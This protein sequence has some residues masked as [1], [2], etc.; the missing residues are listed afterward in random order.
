MIRQKK[1]Q[2]Q[3][4]IHEFIC[5]T[6]ER[7]LVAHL[8]T[9][10]NKEHDF[11]F[12]SFLKNLEK[13]NWLSIREKYP[14]MENI[15]P[16]QKNNIEQ[17][18]QDIIHTFEKEKSAIYKKG[19]LKNE[20]SFIEDINIGKGDF[21]Q[22]KSTSILELNDNQKVI[23]KPTNGAIS[24][25]YFSFLDWVNESSDLGDY[26]YH[27]LNKKSY[28]WQE[29]VEQKE[30]NT[31]EEISTYYKRAGKLLCVLYLLNSIDFHAENIIAHGNTPVIIDHET[32]LQTNIET[33]YSELFLK[34]DSI[35]ADTVFSNN[36][37]VFKSFLLPNKNSKKLVAMG[38]CGLGWSKNTYAVSKVKLGENR[39]TKDWKIT[40]QEKKYSFIKNNLPTLNNKKVYVEDHL[41]TFVAGYQEC[42]ELFISKKGFLA[43]DDSP[44]KKFKNVPVRYIWRNT[45][46][47]GTILRH[48]SAP[49]NLK[50][51]KT[52][53]LKIRKYLSVAFK[54][55]PKD[56]KLLYI[57]EHEVSQMLRG[58]IP[59]FEVDSSSR[60]LVTEHGTIKNFFELSCLE[61]I[62]RKLNKL[63]IEDLEHQKKL[64][65]ENVL[66]SQEVK[67][68]TS[69]DMK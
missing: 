16:M 50:D 27:I 37:S 39:F 53:E 34:E 14:V 68:T 24:N 30:C 46:I 41:D 13:N 52:Y 65:I 55:I 61:N 11:S 4:K 25:S 58:D 40:N 22:G 21:H 3:N 64:I 20:E 31:Q 42:Y 49:S 35:R 7:V 18:Y 5:K 54:N 6:N 44:L 45:Y 38:M 17:L 36:D 32:I 29:F 69:H 33:S 57:L 28:H 56:S 1:F 51:K 15:F 10:K 9:F 47:Y 12:D 43:S 62:E 2:P 8:N 26:K 59:Y 48:M 60:D 67:Q 66:D 23:Y 19:I 63:S